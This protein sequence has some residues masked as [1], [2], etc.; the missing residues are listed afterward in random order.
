MKNAFV[1]VGHEDFGK[2]QTMLALKGP[3]YRYCKIIPI[4]GIDYWT[5]TRSNDDIG[6]EVLGALNKQKNNG[7][8]I[9]IVLCPNFTD[10]A[11]YTV[12]ILNLLQAHYKI[13]FFVLKKQFGR[14]GE[15][16]VSEIAQLQGYGT[17]QI[18]L[19][20]DQAIRA[21]ELTKLII[22]NP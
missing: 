12:D 9:I 1:V 21:T 7:R 2:T 16:S 14:S 3:T 18:C 22:A 11:K 5:R 15:V 8:H 19:P 4:N 20:E 13:F 17:V 6:K 10:P